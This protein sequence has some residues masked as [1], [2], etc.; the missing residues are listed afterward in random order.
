MGRLVPHESIG[1]AVCPEVC[2]G[3]GM[4]FGDLRAARKTGMSHGR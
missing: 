4:R 2:E 3:L 1:S